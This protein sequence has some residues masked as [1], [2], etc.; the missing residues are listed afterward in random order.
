MLRQI[1]PLLQVRN[2]AASIAFYEGRLGFQAGAL[3]GGFA[4]LRR[5]GCVIYLAQKTKDADVT[6]KAAR[7]ADDGWCNYD[8]HIDCQPGTLDGLYREFRAKG[9][10]MP[11]AFK[12]GPV[13]RDYGVRDFSV[14]DP[15]GYDLVFGE[16][17]PEDPGAHPDSAPNP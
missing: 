7:A 4:I 14:I 5:D 8:L 9:V 2:L 10:P 3:G 17:C 11:D 12:G 6:N 1:I 13:T 15:D 16:E